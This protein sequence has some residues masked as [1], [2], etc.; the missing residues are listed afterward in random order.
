[1]ALRDRLKKLGLAVGLGILSLQFLGWA[2]VLS[3]SESLPEPATYAISTPVLTTLDHT[4]VAVALPPKT[5]KILPNDVAKY[6]QYGYGVW[7]AGSGLG[8]EKRLDLMPPAY[9]GPSAKKSAPLLRFFAMTDIHITD[10]QSPAQAIYF[11]LQPVPGMQAA[12]SPII[13]YTT[14]VLDAA[15][16]TVNALNKTQAFDFGIFLG[17]AINNGQNNELRWYIDVLDGQHINP[18]SDP[19]SAASNDY[20]RPYRAAGLDK[21]ISWYQVLGNHDHFW[22]GMYPPNDRIKGTMVGEYVLNIGNV[23]TDPDLDHRGY[24][25][26]VVDGS[27]ADQ[28]VIS[29][30]PEAGYAT[31]P[32][33]NANPDRHWLPRNEWMAS[34]FTTTSRPAGHGFSRDSVKTGFACYTFEPKASLPL[35]VIVLDDT[36][37]DDGSFGKNGNGA[38]GS[39]DQERYD[40]LVKELDRGQA[41]GKLMIVAAHVPIGVDKQLWDSASSPSENA[42]IDK[43]HTYSNLILWIAGHRHYN[44]V[45]PFP[46]KDPVNHPEYGFWEVETASLRDFPQQFRLFDLVRNSDDTVS[47]L[48]TD[49]DP[50]VGKGSPAAV[51]RSYAIAADQIFAGGP[52]LPY[53]PTGAYNAELVKH[54]SAEM[55]AKVA[56]LP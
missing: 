12:Y 48:T 41:E 44:T 56:T 54:L 29:S 8:L 45:T 46:P 15:A 50:S 36:E 34:F 1:M 30:G 22:S 20:T 26:G 21:S 14:H 13:P 9:R 2:N 42:L 39:L 4:V 31:P 43:L 23:L 37:K 53:L 25:T 3:A 47:I 17:D 10:V 49:V 24:Y 28:K 51:S 18:N 16:Q 52:P 27:A 40:W 11:G 33:V 55:R 32:R 6:S 7:Q 35:R 38:S 5:P 19:K